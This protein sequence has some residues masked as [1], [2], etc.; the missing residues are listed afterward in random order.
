MNMITMVKRSELFW[1]ILNKNTVDKIN[2]IVVII[3][4]PII[5]AELRLSTKGL[6]LIKYNTWTN[7]QTI[8][9]DAWTN[10]ASFIQTCAIRNKSLLNKNKV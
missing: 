10:S 4:P 6:Y 8:F 9:S 3:S 5:E 7:A 2:I 1:S